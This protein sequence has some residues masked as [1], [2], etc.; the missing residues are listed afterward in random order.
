M[1][2][3]LSDFDVETLSISNTKDA[4]Y[5]QSNKVPFELQTDWVTLG[6][7]PLP[8]KK[9]VTDDAK[10]MNLTIPISKDDGYYRVMTAIDDNLSKL[11]ISQN[12]K[13]HSLISEKDDN[14]C[15]KFKLYLDTGLFDKD[16]NRISITSLFDFYKY[17]RE[18]NQINIVFG[19]SKLWQ[20]GKE[21]GFSLSVKRILLKNEVK[22]V[23]ETTASFLDN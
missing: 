1:L 20:M 9:H 21:Y 4:T 23:P 13:Y 14:H 5:L 11:N 8:S 2:Y 10:S 12:K 6:K 19:F 17:M 22:E 7:Y 3:K 16:K 18:D 15:L